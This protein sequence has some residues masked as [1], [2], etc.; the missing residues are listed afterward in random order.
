M[1]AERAPR[2]ILLQGR[3]GAGKDTV[4]D[5]VERVCDGAV[6]RV[7]FADPLRAATLR[8]LRLFS[9]PGAAATPE[10]FT[11]RRLKEEAFAGPGGAPWVS[12]VDPVDLFSGVEVT[13]RVALRALGVIMRQEVGVGVWRDAGVERMR[14]AVEGGADVVV[15][16]DARFPSEK[17]P[18]ERARMARAAGFASVELWWVV[19][20]G[21]L[22]PSAE[23]VAAL[24]P[25]ERDS[26]TGDPDHT[27]LND[28]SLGFAPLEARV[29]EL[30][31]RK[32]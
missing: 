18:D 32:N 6:V 12:G 15:V 20:P 8:V 3:A 21:G 11:D 29:A 25:T 26:H 10:H 22:A 17:D 9:G 31:G 1:A 28:K 7:S 13:P 19:A 23:E 24:P 2:L 27:I 4:A 5:M 30:L 16:T 14:K